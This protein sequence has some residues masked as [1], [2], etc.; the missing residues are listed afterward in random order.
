MGN[1]RNGIETRN[2]LLKSCR[3]LFY[4]T[5][6][7]TATIKDIV[8]DA[9]SKLGL[10]TYYFTGK[11]AA[12]LEIYRDFVEQIPQKLKTVMGEQYPKDM[13][14]VDMTEYRAF[15]LCIHANPFISRFYQEI[16]YV[17]LFVQHVKS[18]SQHF[19]QQIMLNCHPDL[20]NTMLWTP[21]Y[22]QAIISLIAGMEIQIS[23]DLLQNNIETSYDDGIDLFLE[24]YYRFVLK[25]TSLAKKELRTSRLLLQQYQFQ[26]LPGFEVRIE[27][28]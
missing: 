14:L 28:I 23:R 11:E 17:N 4:E 12:G 10:F 9:S 24:E 6:Y 25:E 1:Y 19:I 26:V 3:K 7:S 15:F 21:D 22:R 2:N 16:S 20:L 8:A 13:I 18:I 5:G 27:K